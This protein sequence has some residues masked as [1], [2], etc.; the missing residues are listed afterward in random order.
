MKWNRVCW[1]SDGPQDKLPTS[2]VCKIDPKSNCLFRP[3]DY[4]S[5]RGAAWLNTAEMLPTGNERF[6]GHYASLYAITLYFFKQ[7]L[8]SQAVQGIFVL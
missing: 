8:P 3:A 1:P 7:R 6:G 5:Q 2:K 4:G